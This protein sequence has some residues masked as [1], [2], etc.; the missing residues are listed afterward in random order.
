MIEDLIVVEAEPVFTRW[1][2]HCVKCGQCFYVDADPAT[3]KEEITQLQ[4]MKCE[5]H[6]DEDSVL[7]LA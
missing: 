1:Q 3:P 2:I 4:G 6:P 7:E 5:F